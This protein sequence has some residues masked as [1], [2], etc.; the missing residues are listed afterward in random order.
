MTNQLNNYLLTYIEKIDQNLVPNLNQ[1][2]AFFKTNPET[3]NNSTFIN[4]IS[5]SVTDLAS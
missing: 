2:T 3:V 4:S 5:Q 1:I